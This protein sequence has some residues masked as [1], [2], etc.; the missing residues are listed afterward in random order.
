MNSQGLAQQLR[1]LSA[2][3]QDPSSFQGPTWQL[4]IVSLQFWVIHFLFWPQWVLHTH[5]TNTY[6]QAN[7]LTYKI[8]IHTHT[9]TYEFILLDSRKIGR[10]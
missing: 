4:T 7:T 5:G 1:E 9:H 8:K 10:L 2:L 6:I 3:A